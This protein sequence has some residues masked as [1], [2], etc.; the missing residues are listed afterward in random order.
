MNPD[1]ERLHPYPFEKLKALFSDLP[2]SD[3]SPIALSIGE[4]KHP[5]PDFVQQVLRDSTANG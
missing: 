5:S 4:P 2:A 1:L 3:K